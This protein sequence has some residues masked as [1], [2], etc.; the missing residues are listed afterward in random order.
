MRRLAF[1]RLRRRRERRDIGCVSSFVGADLGRTAL[2]NHLATDFR[3]VLTTHVQDQIAP[4]RAER[5][6]AIRHAARGEIGPA[7]QRP[8]FLHEE[9]AHRDGLVRVNGHPTSDVWSAEVQYESTRAT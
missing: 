8:N 1:G 9:S 3:P 2:R 7:G 4:A 6:V 5:H